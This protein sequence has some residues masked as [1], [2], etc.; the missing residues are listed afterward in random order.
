MAVE[1]SSGNEEEDDQVVITPHF[2]PLIMRPPTLPEGFR[3]PKAMTYHTHHEVLN[4][5]YHIQEK[6]TSKPQFVP[7]EISKAGGDQG[8]VVLQFK[9]H[10][11][12]FT[13]TKMSQARDFLKC[14]SSFL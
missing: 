1:R 14:Q 9:R 11:R 2:S 7:K 5:A 12:V 13:I 3:N 8:T 10:I 6:L 4:S